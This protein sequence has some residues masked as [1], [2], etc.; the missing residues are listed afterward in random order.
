MGCSQGIDI[1]FDL[2]ILIQM[3]D[4]LM[5]IYEPFLKEEIELVNYQPD[6]WK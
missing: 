3:V 5:E 1:H 6:A 2:S 4:G